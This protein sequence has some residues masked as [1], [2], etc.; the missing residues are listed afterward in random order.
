MSEAA[1]PGLAQ[2]PKARLPRLPLQPEF[3]PEAGHEAL[4]KARAAS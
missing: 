1:A 3:A 2:A 4:R